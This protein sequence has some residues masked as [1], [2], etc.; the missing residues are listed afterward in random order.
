[1]RI[2][3]G[4][5]PS[6]N[7]HLGN[8]FGAIAQF[9][10]KQNAGDELFIFI[11]DWHALTTVKN[12]ADLRRSVLE[13]A[14]AYL[15]LGLNPEKVTLYK[16]SDIKEIPEFTWILNCIAP[17]G[18]LER[19]HSFKDKKAK[20]FEASVGLFDYPVLMAADI[21]IVK[22]GGVP[23]GKD[24]KQH[25]EIA[26]DLADK[27][28]HLYGE[29]FELPDPIIPTEVATIPGVDG[30]K[31]SKSYKNT[32]DLFGSDAE[33]KKQV[34]GIVTSSTPKGEPLDYAKC[35]VFAI[36]KL[37]GSETEIHALKEKYRN[38]EVG[39][40]DA[41]KML[42][43]KIHEKFDAAR[44]KFAQLMQNPKEVEAVLTK[45]A[46]KARKIAE[47]TLAEVRKKVGLSS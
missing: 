7:L 10:E 43:E 46:L 35:N 1:M 44:E 8:Y 14:A 25:V 39:Y 6:G 28:N 38:G 21:L 2:L 34:M 29:T 23:V 30:E 19:A 4:I 26:R 31:M 45:G 15:A 22:P 32:I 47:V 24:Q 20:G 16:Q 11:A 36:Y 33:L 42:L 41:K 9:L 5:Q 12:P 40:G 3:S 17:M 37:L 27:F 18:L 13:V